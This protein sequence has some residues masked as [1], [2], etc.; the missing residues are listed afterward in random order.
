MARLRRRRRGCPGGGAAPSV[1]GRSRADDRFLASLAT[2]ARAYVNAD[3]VRARA[4]VRERAR[5]CAYV[6]VRA[7]ACACAR[8]RTCARACVRARACASVRVRV[9]A[10]VRARATHR[11]LERAGSGV[12]VRRR[13]RFG[14]ELQPEKTRAALRNRRQRAMRNPARRRRAAKSCREDPAREKDRR[15]RGHRQREELKEVAGPL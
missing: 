1:K 9:R 8:V 15:T 5:A 13:T 10:S 2:R 14:H 11:A 6:R 7:R 3:G 4:S 12:G